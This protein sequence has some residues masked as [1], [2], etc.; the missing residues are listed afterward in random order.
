MTLEEAG[1]S[2]QPTLQAIL[3]SI[4]HAVLALDPGLRIVY[5]NLAADQLVADLAGQP[6]RS[7]LYIGDLLREGEAA[8]IV[9]G[10]RRV[11]DGALSRCSF[12]YA[13]DGTDRTIEF[14]CSRIR[15]GSAGAV[16]LVEDITAH[17]RTHRRL[18]G[19]RRVSRTLAR[20]DGL[21]DAIA[22]IIEEAPALTGAE[23]GAV[24]M[25]DEEDHLRAVG[26]WGLD[27]AALVAIERLDEQ[28]YS[29]A[30]WAIHNREAVAIPNLGAL[31][32]LDLGL[33]ALA[34]LQ[35]AIA[36]PLLASGRPRGVLVLAFAHPVGEFTADQIATVEAI[37]DELATTFQR[38]ELVDRLARE[39]LTDA[40]TGLANRR[41]FEDALRRHHAR[42]KRLEQPYGIL[43][44]DIDDMKGINDRY[45]HA[46]GDA[47]L[48]L[49]GRALMVA[50]RAGDLVSRVGGDEF[51]VLVAD[52][53]RD[54]VRLVTDRLRRS[55]PLSLAWKGRH[56]PVGF[57]VGGAA[58][59]AD[60]ASSEAV[61]QR[62]DEA[63][64]RAKRHGKKR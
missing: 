53:D 3:D 52:A 36:V 39:A 29:L 42:A 37:G 46:A 5:A 23:I 11:V 2:L 16:L 62:A 15:D 26:G 32:G 27:P 4:D 49:V 14:L 17:V 57:S 22:A 59:P 45:G 35:A 58:F 20:A 38:A 48:R 61:L 19:L 31:P 28:E 55:A 1:T 43:M 63:L 21:K 60:G 13:V 50:T 33:P 64:Y 34:Q 25:L 41:A 30:A 6:P 10:F 44:A 56:I 51:A 12:Q 18:E 8:Q 9:N 24:Y 7:G 54:G 47:A 40:V